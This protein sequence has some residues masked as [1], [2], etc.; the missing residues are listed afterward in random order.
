MGTIPKTVGELY[1]LLGYMV[2]SG[3]ELK[4]RF[5]PEQNIE[6]IFSDLDVGLINVRRVLGDTALQKL[7]DAS[8]EAK[9]L[10]ESGRHVE[11]NDLLQHMGEYIRLRKYKTD[12]PVV[13]EGRFESGQ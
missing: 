9:L 6:T 7:S 4:S 5:V 11:G 2:L 10:Y 13:D 8:R 3:P 12:E 1:D